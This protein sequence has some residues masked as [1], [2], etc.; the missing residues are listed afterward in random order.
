MKRNV[1]VQM[2]NVPFNEITKQLAQLDDIGYSYIVISPPQK[3]H[4]STDWWGRYQPVDFTV[5]DGPLGNAYELQNLCESAKNHGIKI[6]ADAVLNHMCNEAVYLKVSGNQL[7]EA[8]YPRFSIY[9]FNPKVDARFDP[10]QGWLGN[11]LPDLNTKSHYVRNELKNY[12]EL[13]VKLGVSGFR[14]DAAK[15]IEPEFFEYVL[16]RINHL[17]LFMFGEI[18]ERDPGNS[19]FS[20]YLPLMDAFDFPLASTMRKA[21]A[22]GGQ[23]KDLVNP[24]YNRQ[25]L[26]GFSAITFVKHHDTVHNYSSFKDFIVE[27]PE[28]QILALGYILARREGTPFIYLD[29]YDN[30]I[31]KAGVKFHNETLF[32]DEKWVIS[33]EN[34][35][36][37]KRGSYGFA[38]INKSGDVYKLNTSNLEIGDYIDL[39]NNKKIKIERNVNISDIEIPQ[40]GI[41]FFKKL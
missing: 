13:L 18:V 16:S 40:R 8:N 31:V 34:E 9:D 11:D 17:G 12:L 39:Q 25:A 6:I 1:I 15:H 22:Y 5:I 36:V 41:T 10:D 28:D 26:S 21:F 14:F 23:L 20:S 3:S 35:L 24:S 4:S 7:I 30:P 27:N 29:D 33:A 38:V 37:V 2:F 19:I 32:H